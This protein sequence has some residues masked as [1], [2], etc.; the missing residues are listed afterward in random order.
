MNRAKSLLIVESDEEYRDALVNL[1]AGQPDFKLVGAAATLDDTMRLLALTN[2]AVVL[3][4]IQLPDSSGTDAAQTI[5]IKSPDTV[6][7]FL[8]E[9]DDDESLF[10]SI[11]AGAK[12]YLLKNTP[13]TGFLAALR[14]LE[15]G[16]APISRSMAARLVDEF[17]R[18]SAEDASKNHILDQLTSRETEVLRELVKGMT[19]RE[20]AA[21]L[22]ISEY[23]V[24]NHLHSILEKLGVSNRREAMSLARRHGLFD[25]VPESFRIQ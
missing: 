22:Y 13:P 3:L 24:K 11:R 8:S 21:R 19:N 6:I 17:T 4:S 16:Q 25:Q 10:A 7:V 20:I 18:M 14:G 1:F 12:G 9:M 2:P 5:L 23:T 15:D